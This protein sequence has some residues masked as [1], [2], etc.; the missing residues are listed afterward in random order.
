MQQHVAIKATHSL[1]IIEVIHTGSLKWLK[2]QTHNRFNGNLNTTYPDR[3]GEAITHPKVNK[4]VVKTEKG[5][6]EVHVLVLSHLMF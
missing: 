2:T 1:I 6:K 5:P 3:E 4:P